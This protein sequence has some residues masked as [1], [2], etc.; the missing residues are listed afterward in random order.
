MF[1]GIAGVERVPQV[2]TTANLLYYGN[3]M[4]LDELRD[5]DSSGMPPHH[6]LKLKFHF[7]KLKYGQ[8]FKKKVVLQSL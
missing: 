2:K 4:P 8:R 1:S 6:F 7:Y 3:V 5:Q